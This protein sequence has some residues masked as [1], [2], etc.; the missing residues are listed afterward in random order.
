MIS[1]FGLEARRTC[2][3]FKKNSTRYYIG[4]HKQPM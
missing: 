1:D 3:V 2:T 4:S